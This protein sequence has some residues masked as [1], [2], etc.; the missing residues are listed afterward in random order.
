LESALAKAL[1]REIAIGFTPAKALLVQWSV[2][3]F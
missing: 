1:S 2:K 3:I